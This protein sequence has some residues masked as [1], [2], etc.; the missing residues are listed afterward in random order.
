MHI[1]LLEVSVTSIAIE[2]K[3]FVLAVADNTCIYM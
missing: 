1:V 3:S 2:F